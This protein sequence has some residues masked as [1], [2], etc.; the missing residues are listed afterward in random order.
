MEVSRKW[1]RRGPRPKALRWV[2]VKR[3]VGRRIVTWK[4]YLGSYGMG[5]P[6]FFGLELAAKGRYPREWLVLTLWG[7][8]GWLLLDGHWIEAHP[9][10]YHVQCP[11][12]SNFGDDED[13]DDLTTRIAGAE[14]IEAGISDY[15]SKLVLRKGGEERILELPEDT[16]RLSIWGG[17]LEPKKWNRA[18]SQLDAWVISRRGELFTC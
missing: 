14:I 2:G 16:N 7:A 9:N 1:W 18:E 15:S 13:W 12:F 4:N 6:G 10:Q 17:S 3:I 5:G 11:L 8:G